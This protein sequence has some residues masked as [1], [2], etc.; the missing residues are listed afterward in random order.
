MNMRRPKGF[1]LIELLV[2]IA[3]IGVLIA[4]L[5]PAVQAAR[6]AARR[7]Q[8]VNNLRQ[9]GLAAHNYHSAV[10]SFPMANATAYHDIGA[11]DLTDW[12][13][14]SAQAFLLPYLEQKPVYDA[15]NFNWTCWW[16]YGANANATAFNTRLAVFICPSDG[17]ETTS[18]GEPMLNN[19]HGSMGTTTDIWNQSSTGM[20]AHRLSIKESSVKDGLSN[21]I[22]FSEALVGSD[23]IGTKW[24]DSVTGTTG[25]NASLLNPLVPVGGQLQ[26]APAVLTALQECTTAFQGTSNHTWNRGWRWGP[27]SPGLTLFNTVVTPNSQQYQWS[28][29]RFGCPGCGV[30]FGNFLNANS[31]HPGG[32]NVGMAD[33]SV[34]FIKDSIAPQTWWAIGTK[35]GGETVSSDSYQ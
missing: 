21:T 33:G 31:S 12:G 30:D 20:F 24:R 18:W 23:T 8:C 32:V 35:A 26:F 10:G 9:L 17:T 11:T 3:I 28:G 2:V 27:G 22:L 25:A 16:G 13:T 6:E 5:L 4:L 34:K 1:T 15:M 29:C 7:S 19:Y 14:W